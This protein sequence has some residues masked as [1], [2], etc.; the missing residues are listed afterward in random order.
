MEPRN[1]LPFQPWRTDWIIS[2]KGVGGNWLCF[3]KSLVSDCGGLASAQPPVGAGGLFDA[4]AFTQAGR[5]LK[6][7]VFLANFLV[8]G[9]VFARQ[10]GRGSMPAATT[11]RRRARD[12]SRST[13]ECGVIG[14]ERLNPPSASRNATLD[15]P[16]IDLPKGFCGIVSKWRV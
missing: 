4:G 7:V 9:S 15:S 5:A 13:S 6:V 3:V 11:W 2:A 10:D 12:A 16:L 14:P 8:Q 1:E